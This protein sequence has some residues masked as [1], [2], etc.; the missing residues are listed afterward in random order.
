MRAALLLGHGGPEQIVVRRN[1]P[2]P[3]TGPDQAMIS[4]G[5]CGVNNTDI[6]T[7]IGW[8]SPSVVDATR[9]VA[10][11]K[12]VDEVGWRGALKFPRIQGADICGT[13]VEVGAPGAVHL[14]GKRVLVD[15]WIRI[16]DD[17]H[18]AAAAGYVGSECDGGFA[19]YACVPVANV[20]PIESTLSDVEL[21]T[22]PCS[23]ATAL[24]MLRR[25]RLI[26]GE[27]VVITGASGGVGSF[28]VQ[29]ARHQ[30]ARAIAIASESKREG[31]LG[32]GA[33]VVIPRECDDLSAA[34]RDAT[35]GSVDVVAD[36][37][38]GAEQFA[39]LL[40]ALRPGGRYVTAGAIGG[41]IV[42][43]DLRSLYLKDLEL[44]GVTSF[45]PSLFS[46]LVR[47][48]ESGALRP[49]VGGVFPLAEMQAAQAFFAAKTHL[50]S[51]V[52]SIAADNGPPSH[53]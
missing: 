41:P 48:I 26:A 2:V 29:L 8:Y 22:F 33:D 39:A 38:G 40:D 47:L 16:N 17:P 9:E 24:N 6:N 13:V 36:V 4:V 5:A 15:P 49:T 3:V 31:V 1:V 14:I 7:R 45:A 35:G 21:A 42:P 25:V 53:L 18:D 27:T 10:T 46:D 12:V 28:A 50:G 30:G 44:H 51:I 19:E 23:A 37:V 11:D 52:I 34:I 43:L 20:H 32:L